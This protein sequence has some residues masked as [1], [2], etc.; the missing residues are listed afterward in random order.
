MCFNDCAFL[1]RYLNLKNV[2]NFAPENHI[3]GGLAI[4]S[5]ATKNIQLPKDLDEPSGNK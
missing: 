3:E 1:S 4:K 2:L 5:F